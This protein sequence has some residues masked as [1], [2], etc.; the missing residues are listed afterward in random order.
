M[1][2]AGVCPDRRKVPIVRI[3]ELICA[4][5]LEWIPALTRRAVVF[6]RIRVAIWPTGSRAAAAAE[7]KTSVGMRSR[8]RD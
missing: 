6:G 7:S 3:T 5:T 1:R 4:G 2:S 8:C